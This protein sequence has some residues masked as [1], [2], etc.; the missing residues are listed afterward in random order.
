MC[1]HGS[2]CCKVPPPLSP[3]PC[4]PRLVGSP[5]LICQS[6]WRSLPACST[7]LSLPLPAFVL[8]FPSPYLLPPP[9]L[10]SPPSP[11]PPP[12][13]PL[14]PTPTPSPLVPPAPPPSS[15]PSPSPPP[16]PSDVCLH[17]LAWWRRAPP[18]VTARMPPPDS[19]L[20][21]AWVDVSDSISAE[22]ATVRTKMEELSK[23]HEQALRPVFDDDAGAARHVDVEVLAQDITRRL[24][25]CDAKLRTLGSFA[26]NTTDD[27]RVLKNVQTSLA[28]ELQQ[29]TQSFRKKQKSY[30]H[31]LR[32]QQEDPGAAVFASDHRKR[33]D[34]EEADPGFSEMQIKMSDDMGN[35]AK[36]REQEINKIVD[37]VND[38]AS[39]MQDLALLVIDQGTILD[40][41][42]Y[43]V[44][45]VAQKVAS[46]VVQLEKAEQ[47]QRKN[48]MFMCIMLLLVACLVM[49]LVLVLK[50]AIL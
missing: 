34:E 38:L 2:A 47:T 26:T 5:F 35:L 42:D 24:K 15:L 7:C 4:F 8:P 43:N 41:I 6:P 44:E 28:A 49:S 37:S 19:V 12:P 32:L 13:P 17:V 21:P 31:A 18:V 14:P 39:V 46:G 25:R 16:S 50:K 48:R 23:E 36:E 45:I 20:P 1:A 3:P 11:F 9:P 27:E 40:R 10:S 22:I 29:L 30:L 33:E